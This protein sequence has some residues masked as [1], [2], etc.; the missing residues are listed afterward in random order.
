MILSLW[1]YIW[2]SIFYIFTIR[3]RIDA[4]II[5]TVVYSMI[6]SSSYVRKRWNGIKALRTVFGVH[7]RYT[8][9][10]K[11]MALITTGF[12]TDLCGRVAIFYGISTWDAYIKLVRIFLFAPYSNI[13]DTRL[14]IQESYARDPNN[15]SLC[16]KSIFLSYSY[17]INHVRANLQFVYTNKE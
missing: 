9:M 8:M 4:S 2:N 10:P 6:D 3:C 5:G 17:Y 12:D 11:I 7:C 15:K 13:K 14:A 1:M 16:S